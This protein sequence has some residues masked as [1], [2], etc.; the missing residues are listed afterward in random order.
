M[1]IVTGNIIDRNA[2]HQVVTYYMTQDNFFITTW[3]CLGLALLCA[4][5]SLWTRTTPRQ[6]GGL[7]I[8][9]VGVTGLTVAIIASV[10]P[11]PGLFLPGT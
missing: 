4:L 7:I 10:A 9:G 2:S 1:G 11:S 3:I 5:S 6:L 8:V